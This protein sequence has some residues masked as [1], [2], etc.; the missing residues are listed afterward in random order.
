MGVAWAATCSFQ[1]AALA[2]SLEGRGKGKNT[3]FY[4]ES[5]SFG[6]VQLFRPVYYREDFP[7]ICIHDGILKTQSRRRQD[8]AHNEKFKRVD[9]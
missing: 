7:V 1:C 6:K 9:L 2:R 3:S 4:S 5:S 8:E